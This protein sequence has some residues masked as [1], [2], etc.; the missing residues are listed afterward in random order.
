MGRHRR[1]QDH[2]GR[3][4][5]KEGFAARSAYKLEELDQRFHI[6]R[7]GQRILDLGCSPGS[8]MQYAATRVGSDG[9]VLG[10]D[11]KPT[12]AS[13]PAHAQARVGDVWELRPENVEGPFDVVLSDM[14]PATMGDKK[15]DAL[16]S[17]GL[18]E[19]ALALAAV[20]LRPG[21]HV[22]V[23]ILEGGGVPAIVDGM[24][25]TYDK[26]QRLRPKATRRESTEIFV[27]GLGRKGEGAA[28]E[29]SEDSA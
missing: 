2:F 15:T 7:R 20:H 23:K 4:A 9:L 14:A 24:R 11:L 19:A 18:A 26:V 17:E 1:P 8:W 5:K 10:Y 3:R 28:E 22:V 6:F 27:I 25:K 13:L 21:G 12:T 29:S 16:R